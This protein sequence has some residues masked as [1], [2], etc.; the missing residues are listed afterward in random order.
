MTA[1]PPVGH[2]L[3]ITR[4]FPA[5]PER[6]WRAWTNP[7]ELAR[8]FSPTPHVMT[9]SAEM[10]ARVGGSFRIALDVSPR[11]AV[12]L[13][14]CL[15]VVPPSRLVLKWTWEPPHEFEGIDT[16]LTVM[17]RGV[18]DGTELTLHHEG[19]PNATARRKHS[20]GHAGALENLDRL[21]RA[22]GT[23]ARKEPHEND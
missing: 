14:T 8:W 22:E 6:V 1:P 18:D 21:L 2:I 3:T 9:A 7:A 10:D 20:A 11:P 17:L 19:L 23:P 15:E 16:R 5:P 4:R 13:G 12:I